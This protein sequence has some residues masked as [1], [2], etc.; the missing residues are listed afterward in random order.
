[1]SDRLFTILEETNGRFIPLYPDRFLLFHK[2]TPVPGVEQAAPFP[3]VL[4]LK[5]GE[6]PY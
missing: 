4:I 3:P 1:M 2:R 5:P 6:K